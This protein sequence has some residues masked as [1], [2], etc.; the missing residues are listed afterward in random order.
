MKIVIRTVCF[1]FLC[2]LI[3]SY[4]YFKFRDDFEY[5]KELTPIDCISL[6]AT[7]QSGVGIKIYR[8]EQR[9]KRVEK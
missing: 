2:I 8:R 6:S 3:F 7:I 4:F 1:H 5:K 9:K